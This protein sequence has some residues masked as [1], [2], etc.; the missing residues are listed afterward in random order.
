MFE[1]WQA[2]RDTDVAVSLVDW[3]RRW[4]SCKKTSAVCNARCAGTE[5]A[6]RDTLKND[7]TFD[8]TFLLE[9]SEIQYLCGFQAAIRF[10]LRTKLKAESFRKLPAFF[11]LPMGSGFA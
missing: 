9:K 1:H 7:G 5:G 11:F 10:L 8:G 3:T 4:G 2:M 6:T